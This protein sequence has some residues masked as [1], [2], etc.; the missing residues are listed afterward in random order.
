MTRTYWIS[1]SHPPKSRTSAFYFNIDEVKAETNSQQ[2]VYY[3]FNSDFG[4]LNL[5]QTH[6][7]CSELE[8]LFNVRARSLILSLG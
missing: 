4:P 2:L 5:A 3:G 8:A 6:R 1:D 7:F